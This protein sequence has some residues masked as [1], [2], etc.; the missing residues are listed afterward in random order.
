[1][2]EQMPNVLAKIVMHKHGEVAL[3]KQQQPLAAFISEVKPSER[4]FLAALKQ[5]GPRFILECKK[6]SPSKGLI[7]ADFNLEELAQVYGQYADC[8]S[9]LTD[10]QFFQG[11]YEY[12]RTM[13]TLVDK[14]LLHKDFIIDSY[15]IFLGRHCQSIKYDS[16]DR[17][18]QR[19][20]NPARCRT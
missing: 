10:E 11:K 19:S 16:A 1:M 5:K 4:D 15:Q 12:L 2:T 9:V 14:P 18:K 17:S 7:R 13:R 20:R 8:I 3:L 6:A